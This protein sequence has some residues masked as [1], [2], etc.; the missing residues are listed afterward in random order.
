[1]IPGIAAFTAL[2]QLVSAPAGT[3]TSAGTFPQLM[4][5]KYGLADSIPAEGQVPQ[6]DYQF[7]LR[8]QLPAGCTVL[9]AAKANN[10]KVWVVTDAGVF[11]QSGGSTAT[12]VV[13]TLSRA[14]Q[15]EISAGTKIN[16]VCS[17]SQGHI[18][19]A[20]TSG[21]YVTDGANWWERL[22]R[23]DGMPYDSV[24]CVHLAPNGDVWGGTPEGA[25]R[26][27]DGKYRYF[28]GKRWL[29]GNNIASIWTDS[30]GHTWFQTDGG[31]GS[32]FEEKMTLA[33]KA[34][35]FDSITQ[36]RHNR[37]GY[38]GLIHLKTPG[39][40]TA[41]ANYE[42]A[43]SDGLWTAYYVAAQ[44]FRYA[45]T[46][47]ANARQ[48]AKKSFDALLE[49]ERVSGIPGYPARSMVTEEEI[50]AGIKGFNPDALVHVP[51]E[52]DKYWVKSPVVKGL[53]LKTDT[54]SDTLDGHFFAWYLYHDLVADATEKKYIEALVRRSMDSIIKNNYTLIGHSGR[55]TRW[56]VWGPQFLNDDPEWIDQRGINSL[57]L[58]SHLKLS[59][60][61]TGDRKYQQAYDEMIEKYH[62]L[63]NTLLLR[64]GN[65][66]DWWEINHSDDQLA[67]ITFYPLLMLE[68]DPAKR[69]IL[70]QSFARTWE[71]NE[72]GDITQ[73]AEHSSFYNFNYGALTGNYCDAEIGVQDLQ[74]WP[75]D[76]VDWNINNSQRH[77]VK[78]WHKPGTD[79]E[80]DSHL[81][82]VVPSSERWV[83]RWNGNPWQGDGGSNGGIEQDGSTWLIAYWMGVYHGFIKQNQ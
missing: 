10:G 78:I 12:V 82:R 73:R 37:H 55:K 40:P 41:G 39:D 6:A 48:E 77:D 13:P 16:Y 38:I 42:A 20:T 61:L 18:W 25:W 34:E 1:M 43:D 14:G 19:A 32:I 17:D 59:Y 65:L 50:K 4:A 71:D 22:N 67:A 53:W 58:L 52:K 2:L 62:Y 3:G 28:W 5:I 44:C 68:K 46:H 30:R 27:R 72:N 83:K 56:G 26:L 57:D 21:V 49:L 33:K 35:H 23:K 45:S 74:D 47:S 63:Q 24:N 36:Q 81:D 15:I 54:S 79:F 60:H 29:P 66:G 8:S 69:R 51:G 9:S 70:V 64:R 11:Q 80:H 7:V 31:V 76:M 75:W